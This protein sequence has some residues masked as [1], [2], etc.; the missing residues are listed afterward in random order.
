MVRQPFT[1]FSV[2]FSFYAKYVIS[3]DQSKPNIVLIVADDLGWGDVGFT[4]KY[5]KPLIVPD[6]PRL[7]SLA[8]RS[9]I[10]DNF[11]TQ[12]LCT[13]TRSS[14]YTGRCPHRLGWLFSASFVL[15]HSDYLKRQYKTFSE[16]KSKFR[17][18]ILHYYFNIQF[19]LIQFKV[20]DLI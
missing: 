12:T 17:K 1:L 7:D 13:P 6:T 16:V 5:G 4:D 8:Q 2:L 14:I 19:N 3:T 9:I 10:L 20:L 11:Y 18:R 15:G